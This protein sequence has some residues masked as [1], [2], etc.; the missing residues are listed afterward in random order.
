MPDEVIHYREYIDQRITMLAEAH[1][2]EHELLDRALAIQA[3]EYERRL[4]ELN[5]SHAE[6]RRVLATY[7]TR[8]LYE[9]SQ[10][11]LT[12]WKSNI[13]KAIA[14]MA[15][16]NAAYG[17]ALGAAVTVITVAINVVGYFAGR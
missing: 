10:K 13:D 3:R 14:N 8:D 2:R 6:A 15:G 17:I 12:V 9:S 11:D 4:D 1:T 16:R 5:H 7:I